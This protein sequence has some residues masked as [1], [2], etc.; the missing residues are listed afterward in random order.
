MIVSLEGGRWFL[1]W[2]QPLNWMVDQTK[3][4]F[5]FMK[6]WNIFIGRNEQTLGDEKVL[7][8]DLQGEIACFETS[9]DTV[10]LYRTITNHGVFQASEALTWSSNEKDYFYKDQSTVASQRLKHHK[11]SLWTNMSYI[12]TVKPCELI[13][14]FFFLTNKDLTR[15][16]PSTLSTAMVSTP[17]PHP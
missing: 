3:M 5:W 11:L 9:I 4:L 7:C 6:A 13:F 10:V 8:G 2:G 1:D 12:H 15:V 16:P 17:F 14:F